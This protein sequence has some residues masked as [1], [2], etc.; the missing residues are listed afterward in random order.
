MGKKELSTELGS[1]I[2]KWADEGLESIG[3]FKNK[4]PEYERFKKQIIA[5]L[6]S[7]YTDK[8]IDLFLRAKDNR[9]IEAPDGFARITGP[10]G[11]T[12]EIF[13][14][15]N[16]SIIID[17]S[18]Q[19]D[20]CQPSIAA[21]GMVAEMVKG[22]NIDEIRNYTQQDVL[23]SL[24]GLPDDHKHCALLAIN[25]LKEAIDNFYKKNKN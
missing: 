17:S 12:M 8:A 5:Q 22:K 21:G 1:A 14:K 10:C 13:L 20:G 7:L 25:T 23:D 3:V 15:T 19:T 16:N 24:G 18:F 11:D 6:R 4:S 2:E 9:R